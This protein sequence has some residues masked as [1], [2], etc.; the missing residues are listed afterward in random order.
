ILVGVQRSLAGGSQAG[1]GSQRIGHTLEQS[2]GIGGGFGASPGEFKMSA[3]QFGQQRRP[4]RCAEAGRRV[5][6]YAV[7]RQGC[8]GPGQAQ[9]SGGQIKSVSQGPVGAGSGRYRLPGGFG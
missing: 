5:Y 9:P 2:G 8:A 6:L 1:N 7:L 4:Y 3:S